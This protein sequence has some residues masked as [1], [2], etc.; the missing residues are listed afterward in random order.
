MQQLHGWGVQQS[1]LH[2]ANI[3][4]FGMQKLEPCTNHVFG[5]RTAAAPLR[6]SPWAEH[7]LNDVV[8]K[9]FDQSSVCEGDS[10]N[11]MALS[12]NALSY[13]SLSACSFTAD[14]C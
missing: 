11:P 7:V 9:C 3:E 2:F 10:W 13:T 5:C 1:E 12:G 14:S 6:S 8:F 4:S